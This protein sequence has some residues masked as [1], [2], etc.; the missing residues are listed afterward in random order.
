MTSITRRRADKRSK[1]SSGSASGS[2]LITSPIFLGLAALT[3]CALLVSVFL[4]INH[5]D[6]TGRPPNGAAETGGETNNS[7]RRMPEQAEKVGLPHLEPRLPYLPPFATIDNADE[8]AADVLKGKP[9]I[10]GIA[11]FLG[12]FL[13]ALHESN[14]QF[15]AEQNDVAPIRKAY[16]ALAEKHLVPM[17]SVYKGRPIFPVR[18]DESVFISLAAFREHLLGQTLRSAFGQAKNPDKLFV[19]AIIQNCFGIEHTCKTG[20][21][22]IGKNKQGRDMTKI[23][24]APPD[25]NGIEEF[26]QD[27]EFK[28]YCESGQI[29]VVYM[30]DTDALGPAVARYFASKLWGGETFFMQVDSHLEFAKEWDEKYIEEVKVAK[31]YP[32]AVLS[33]YPPG[34]QTFGEYEG[35]TGGPRLCTCTFSDSLVEHQIIRINTGGRC[36]GH[37]PRPTQIAFIAA[38]F[39]FARAEFL[40]DVPFDPFLPWCF[41]G[42]EIALSMRAWTAGWNIYAPRINLIAH[43]YRPVSRF[44]FVHVKRCKLRLISIV[45]FLTIAYFICLFLFQLIC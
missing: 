3:V 44:V 45:T 13:E 31:N 25:A 2:S 42:E 29:R 17:D 32:K 26:C 9:T 6:I 19:G 18:E 41:M 8:L 20:M 21:Q 15:T 27:E 30:R 35:G 28:K 38:G 7:L 34:F 36:T 12:R 39:F 22:V 14:K 43:Q 10:A 1:R 37:E 11:V 24:D 5:D 40:M 23:S 33:M 16:F 4:V